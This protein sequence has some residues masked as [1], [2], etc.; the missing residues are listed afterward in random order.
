MFIVVHL[1]ERASDVNR[2]AVSEDRWTLRFRFII[3]T[4]PTK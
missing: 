3:V 1:A 4:M 2:R